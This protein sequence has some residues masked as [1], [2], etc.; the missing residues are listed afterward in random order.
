MKYS[1]QREL[2]L[3]T[4]M[5]NPV[6]PTA[7]FVYSHLRNANPNIS[8]GTVYRNLNLLVEHGFIHKIAIPNGSD[9]FDFRLDEHYH[10]ICNSCGEVFD[11][12]LNRLKELDTEIEKST[13]F[14]VTGHDLIINGVCNNCKNK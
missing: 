6:H 12:E 14:I 7:D 4:V 3:N 5:E 11:V 1:K 8:L 2:V 10:M 9:R 13:G